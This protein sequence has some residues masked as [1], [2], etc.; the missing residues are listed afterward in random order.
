MSDEFDIKDYNISLPPL[1][2]GTYGRVFRATYRGISDR[3]LKIFRPGAVDLST[4]ARELEKLAS[5]AEHH[6][7][8]TLH[9]FDLLNDPPYYAMG[10]HADQTRDGS[11]ETRT[12]ERLC[13]HVD[14]REAWRLI[15]EIADAMAYLHRHQIVH[16]DMKPSNILLT[17]ETPYGIKIC[18]F[19]QSRGLS[20]EGFEAVGTPLYASPEQLRDPRDSTGGKGFRWDVYSFGVVAFK[21]ITGKLPRL[22]ELADAERN[23]FDPEATLVESSLEATLAEAEGRDRIDGDRL[24]MMTEAVEDVEWPGD[25]SFS[26]EGKDLILSCLSLD[27]LKRPAD[28]REVWNTMRNIDN[29]VLVRRARRLNALFGSLLV[30]ALWASGFAFV[31]AKRAKE[32]TKSA[33]VSQTQAE[34]LALFIVNKLNHEELS[35]PGL[36]ELYDHIADHSE[37]Y[38]E[39]LPKGRNSEKL[40]R[41]SANTAS[42][43]GRQALERDDIE[44]AL[45]KF[46]TAYEIRSKLAETTDEPGDIVWLASRDLLVIGTLEAQRENYEEALESYQTAFDL[47]SENTDFDQPLGL[48]ELRQLT[49]CA[50]GIGAVYEAE[51]DLKDAALIY[52]QAVG[53]FDTALETATPTIAVSMQRDLLTILRA[54]GR[55]EFGLK[56]YEAATLTYQRQLETAQGLENGP[57][58][59]RRE[60]DLAAA[61]ALAALGEIELILKEPAAALSYFREE[62]LLL[63]RLLRETPNNAQLTFAV[64]EAYA[65]AAE[66]LTVDNEPDRRRA[67]S[68]LQQAVSR[69]ASLRPEER[70]AITDIDFLTIYNQ[71]ISNLLALEE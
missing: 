23:S 45:A 64:A 18:D 3:A 12:L 58:Q 43:R 57:P 66:C 41:I 71:K 68:L 38:L 19:G 7:I 8:V 62:T 24:A 44:E 55:V 70:L 69:I 53:W 39:N 4:M 61:N 63:E 31:Q 15:K 33:V 20:V 27:P 21:L 1:G 13:G 52:Q 67:I 48:V 30:V 59:K 5:V 22:Q 2:E 47:R 11:W 54:L 17:D 36:D 37:A 60:A 32:A 49:E 9:D 25:I 50:R 35:G 34:E 28:M 10:L 26:Q 14:H 65:N 6:G 16:C 56:D 40:L 29:Y 42:M 46:R 51:N